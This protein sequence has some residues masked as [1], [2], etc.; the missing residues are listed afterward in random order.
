VCL[1]LVV[2][3]LE[4]GIGTPPFAAFPAHG[5]MLP[6]PPLP[7]VVVQGIKTVCGAGDPCSRHGAAVL[8]YACNASMERKAMYNADGDYLVV[9]QAGVLRIT[10]EFGRLTVGPNEICVLQRGIRFSV[11]VD[12]PSR[13]YILET[14][15]PHLT[16][17]SLGPIGANGLAN[18][19][20]FLTPVA[21][22]EDVDAE[23]TLVARFQGALFACTQPH[24]PFDVVAWHGN[25]A[26]Y[27]YDL[28][29]FMVIG[30]VA[31]DHCDPS[32]FTVLTC[33][34]A[35]P[36]TALCDFVIFPPRWAVQDHTFRPPYFHRNCMSE[37]MGLIAGVYEAKEG[38]G[39]VP[40]GGSLHSVMT[41]HGPDRAAFAKASAATL[42][43]ERVADNTQ[44][45][46][47]ESS[48]SWKVSPWA[49]RDKQPGYLRVW[50]GLERHF[51]RPQ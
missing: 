47:F 45:F 23:Y 40:G 17:P 19:R 21:A 31:F 7:M 22:F 33:P 15:G 18:P 16:L 46:M 37:Y 41:P 5:R 28:S 1:F 10:T 12:G 49:Q 39:F 6:L 38:G 44:A 4:V 24:T 26:P 13:G 11:A 36:G 48:L 42:V 14:Y 32:I 9:P 30:A 3:T 8:L 51:A 2:F 20:D 43:P 35:E 27:K 25:Y 29:R 34:T 50:D